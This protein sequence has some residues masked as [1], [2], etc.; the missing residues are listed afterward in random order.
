MYSKNISTGKSVTVQIFDDKHNNITS[1]F[2]INKPVI[3]NDYSN[4]SINAKSSLSD[5]EYIRIEASVDGVST[6]LINYINGDGTV[7]NPYV[8]RTPYEMMFLSYDGFYSKLG[9]TIDL[10]KEI[11]STYGL[12]YNDG[13]GWEPF[14]F[15]NSYSL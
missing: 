7:D 4:I 8:I 14:N 10:D 3:I 11:K 13:Y 6:S 1:K 15:N 2:N 12:F 9:N 5:Y